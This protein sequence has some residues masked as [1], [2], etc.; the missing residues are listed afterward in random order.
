[1]KSKEIKE[2]EK[3]MEYLYHLYKNLFSNDIPVSYKGIFIYLK[4][5]NL[6][7]LFMEEK[8]TY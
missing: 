6:P 7:K 1:M 5:V 8:E 4:D 2:Q 3:I